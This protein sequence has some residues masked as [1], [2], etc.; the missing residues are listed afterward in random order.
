MS[1]QVDD[2]CAGGCL[3]TRRGPDCL[4][5]AV[6]DDDRPV[7]ERSRTGAVDD[8]DVRERDQRFGH[9]HELPDGRRQ[10]IVALSG[11]G[12]GQQQSRE[13]YDGRGGGQAHDRLRLAG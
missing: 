3:C 1:R 8:A 12:H 9:G 4:D 6:A 2:A 10:A 5:P 11:D 7:L 13:Q